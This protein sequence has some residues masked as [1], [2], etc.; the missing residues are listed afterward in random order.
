MVG[1]LVVLA[2]LIDKSNPN[3]IVTLIVFTVLT[4]IFLMDLSDS[5]RF[6][7][8]ARTVTALLFVSYLAYFVSSITSN[9]KGIYTIGRESG[10]SAGSALLVTLIFGIPSLWY[11]VTGRFPGQSSSRKRHFK[12]FHKRADSIERSLRS[13]TFDELETEMSSQSVSTKYH[14]QICGWRIC[15]IGEFHNDDTI[16]VVMQGFLPCLALCG[17][18]VHVG[19]FRR[20]RDGRL[21][22]MTDKELLA[23][24]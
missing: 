13:L 2:I 12:L 1:S 11:T 10:I 24:D 18:H 9:L 4:S 14:S 7:W 22:S 8:A 17:S 19:G 3:A 23:Y 16:Q 21:E 15:P 6:N 5:K 20:F